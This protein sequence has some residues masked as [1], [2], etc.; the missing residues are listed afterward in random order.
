M[1]QI[2]RNI[3]KKYRDGEIDIKDIANYLI[4]TF[5]VMDIA[6]SL[7]ETFDFEETKPIVIS[8][9]EFEKHFRIRGVRP[10]GTEERRGRRKE[11]EYAVLQKTLA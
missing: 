6:I 11:I 9:E 3:A 5:P 8:Q 7:A 10:D 1:I 2:D 4:T